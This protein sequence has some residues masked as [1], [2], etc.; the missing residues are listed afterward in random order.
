MKIHSSNVLLCAVCAFILI[1]S[2]TSVVPAEEKATYQVDVN[3]S[4]NLAAPDGNR[5]QCY[6]FVPQGRPRPLPVV[7][8]VPPGEQAAQS[9]FPYARTIAEG[10]IAVF[11]YDPEGR[12]KSTGAEDYNGPAHQD[13]VTEVIKYLRSQR[14][15]VDYRNIGILSFFDG[16]TAAVGSLFKNPKLD[17]KYLIDLEGPAT[18]EDCIRQRCPL[19]KE[20]GMDDFFWKDREAFSFIQ[21]IFCRYLRLQ[22]KTDHAMQDDKTYAIRMYNAALKGKSPW[23][24]CN[25][26]GTYTELDPAF[27][28][29]YQ[30]L[31]SADKD[32]LAR[33]VQEMAQMEPLPES[34]K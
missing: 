8:I 4:I 7:I 27:P 19:P 30:W 6:F 33:F 18:R 15:E 11:C 32:V 12:G 17:V 29:K 20:A 1:L 31:R 9:M 10:G 24:R 3:E 5:I 28:G 14:G 21:R 34:F 22:C 13:D 23:A 16:T 2:L 26:N 25:Y